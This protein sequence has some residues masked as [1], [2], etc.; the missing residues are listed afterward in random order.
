MLFLPAA[1]AAVRLQVAS[2]T[3][4][5]AL[6]CAQWRTPTPDRFPLPLPAPQ[7][8]PDAV[9]NA[10]FFP[11]VNMT[12]DVC[13]AASGRDTCSGDSGAALFRRL[14]N[15]V[16]AAVGVASR[17][18]GCALPGRPG[19]YARLFP[20]HGWIN[21]VVGVPIN[22]PVRRKTGKSGVEAGNLLV[23]I[24]RARA[25]NEAGRVEGGVGKRRRQPEDGRGWGGDWSLWAPRRSPSCAVI[26]ALV[27]VRAPAMRCVPDHW[28]VKHHPA[29]LRARAIPRGGVSVHP[30]AATR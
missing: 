27:V 14:P 15:T 28:H 22:T 1:A 7:I 2:H 30:P 21:T 20:A 3:G 25:G 26:A 5:L 8:V 13:A 12:G 29:Q 18:Q 19:V 9:C 4:H 17:G 23:G 6:A 10:T 11:F 16:F 24:K